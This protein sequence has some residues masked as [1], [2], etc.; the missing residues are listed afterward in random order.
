M[1]FGVAYRRDPDTSGITLGL[2]AKVRRM[3]VMAISS[4]FSSKYRTSSSPC[5]QL[6][7]P[8]IDRSK[9]KTRLKVV[10]MS[11]TADVESLRSFFSSPMPSARE[12]EDDT[13]VTSMRVVNGDGNDDGKEKAISLLHV[14]GRQYPVK[15]HYTERPAE[16]V[17]DAALQRIFQ[18]HCKEPM[19]GDVLVFLTGAETINSLQKLVEEFAQNLTTDFPKLLV[20][21]LYA[22]LS[23]SA[24]QRTFERAP[25]N[26]RKIDLEESLFLLIVDPD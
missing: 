6:P 21:P 4:G 18:I 9:R 5:F 1:C 12:V 25:P 3:M 19:P 13:A 17:I 26:T 22:A 15:L 2:M 10:V 20:L 11:A 24:Q 8:A 23:Q 7:L 16:D 14:E